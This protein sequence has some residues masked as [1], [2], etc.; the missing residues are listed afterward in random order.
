MLPSMYVPFVVIPDLQVFLAGLQ[1]KSICG[2]FMCNTGA[3]LL[4]WCR[5]SAVA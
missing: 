2:V 5:H 4:A 3:A 1:A